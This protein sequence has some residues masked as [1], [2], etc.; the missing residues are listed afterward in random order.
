MCGDGLS[1]LCGAC[2]VVFDAMLMIVS[3]AVDLRSRRAV[4]GCSCS[5]L[6]CVRVVVCVDF[7]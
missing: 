4:A 1:C 6:M 5:C 2:V 3:L 7:R